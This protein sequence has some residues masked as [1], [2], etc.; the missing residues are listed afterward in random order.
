MYV[1]RRSLLYT[2]KDLERLRR[3]LREGSPRHE[4]T[5]NHPQCAQDQQFHNSLVRDG[6]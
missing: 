5:G 3:P 2:T 1:I 4:A 6:M